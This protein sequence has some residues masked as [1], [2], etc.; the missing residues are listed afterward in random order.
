MLQRGL[1]QPASPLKPSIR[2]CTRLSLTLYLG[3]SHVT[4]KGGYHLHGGLYAGRIIFQVRVIY[5]EIPV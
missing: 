3:A 2:L 1:S 4:A 5:L